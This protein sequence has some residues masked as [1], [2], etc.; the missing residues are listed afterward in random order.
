MIG[1]IVRRVRRSLDAGERARWAA[2]ERDLA[3]VRTAAGARGVDVFRYPLF[4]GGEHPEGYIDFECRFAAWHL[5]RAEV[6]S[7]L[8]IGSYRP[9]VLGLSAGYDVTALDVRP[10]QPGMGTETILVGD[11]ARIP[12]PDAAFDAVVSLS[13]I[14]HFGLGR[15]GD[16][17]NLD[18]D[19]AAAAEMRRVLRPG[20]TLVVTTSLTAGRAALAF[21]AHR[22]YGL[23]QARAL[24][25]G[26]ERVDERFFSHDAGG[27]VALD[28]ITTAPMGWDVYCACLRK[29]A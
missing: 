11:A 27:E 25:A 14:E 28:R 19:T 16:P 13:S 3:A 15:Y 6:R 18:A 17:L 5:R 26:M 10:R 23:E 9:F 2:Y 12:A 4:E 24:F 1:R 20:G 7:L 22:I 29:P 21:N 8:D